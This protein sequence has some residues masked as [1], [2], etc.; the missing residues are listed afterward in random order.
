MEHAIA[1]L[2]GVSA[3]TFSIKPDIVDI[4]LPH[5][6]TASPPPWCS[7]VRISPAPSGA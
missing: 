4:K 1:A 3:S 7:A 6:P 2:L 5:I